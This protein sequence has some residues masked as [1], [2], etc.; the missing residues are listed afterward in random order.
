MTQGYRSHVLEKGRE[1][2]A[3]MGETGV[4]GH[5]GYMGTP[6]LVAPMFCARSRRCAIFL[7]LYKYTVFFYFDSI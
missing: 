6:L 3:G 7:L 5:M 1:K 4:M 2:G